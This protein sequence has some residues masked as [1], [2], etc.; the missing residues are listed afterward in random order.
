MSLLEHYYRTNAE[1]KEQFEQLELDMELCKLY[2]NQLSYKWRIRAN[3]ANIN[4]IRRWRSVIPSNK[5]WEIKYNQ[6]SYKK[7]LINNM[8]AGKIYNQIMQLMKKSIFDS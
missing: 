2:I 5:L 1:F 6:E 8:S 3:R 4:I 7:F